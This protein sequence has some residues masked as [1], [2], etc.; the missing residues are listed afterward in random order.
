MKSWQIILLRMG[1]IGTKLEEK[2]AI[3]VSIVDHGEKMQ[4]TSLFL[5]MDGLRL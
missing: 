5:V 4:L 1:I 3:M 2:K